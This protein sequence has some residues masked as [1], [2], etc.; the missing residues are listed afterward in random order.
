MTQSGTYKI[1][2]AGRH[3]LT[4]GRD[5]IQ[6][7]HAAVVELVK[8]AYD[9]DSEDVEI[10]F[11]RADEL[12]S[13][14]IT[15]SD[16]GHGMSRE[17]VIH[18]WLV[19]STTDKVDR[20]KSPSGRIMQGRKGVGRYAASVLGSDLW[21][22]T[23]TN[24]GEKT[25]V[26]I[27]WDAF[28]DAAY[29]DDVD[30]LVDSDLTTEGP[31]TR[32]TITGNSEQRKDWD[33]QQFDK[34]RFELRKL[35]SPI[36]ITEK[37]DDF[38]IKLTIKNFP[39]TDDESEIVEPYPIIELFD[40]RVA[41]RIDRNGKGE[42]NYST[43]K[44]R[45]SP[46]EL[47]QF[48][49][50]GPT[51]CG[52]L[53]FDFRVYDRDGDSIR[54]L[55]D[56]GLKDASGSYV[57]NLQARQL[58]NEYNGIGVYRNGFR[59]RPLG[60]PDF[61]WLKLNEQRVQNPSLRIGSNQVIG[62]VQI[63]SEELSGL[64][65]K[66]ARDGLREDRAFDSL[67][68]IAKK[69]LGELETRR[70]RHRRMAGI[71]RTVVR[72]ERQLDRLF[73]SE[74]LK[75]DVDTTLRR[76]GVT[77]AATDSVL[78]IINQDEGMRNQ[79]AEEIRRTVAVYQGQATLGKIVHVI[80]HEGR[81]PLGHFRNETNNLKYWHKVFLENRDRT[82][83]VK[84]LSIVEGIGDNAD[85]L[86]KLFGR[87]DPL[88]AGR[89]PNKT[90]MK[91]K[92]VLQQSIDVFDGELKSTE[93]DV[94]VNCPNNIEFVGWRQDLFTIFTNLIDN[95]IYW[96]REKQSQ[97]RRICIDVNLDGDLLTGIDY[98]DTGPGIDADF[99]VDGVIFEPE[100][101]TKTYGTG[102]GLPIAGEA[103][104]RNGLDLKAL[105]SETGA[106]FRLEPALER[107]D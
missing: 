10:V 32:L 24:H 20:P 49:Q 48:D 28:E 52:E 22:E 75:S 29:L 27:Q 16:H 76:A 87:L 39:S 47:I 19:P 14:R 57:G 84:I 91:L 7:V 101:T 102:L 68:E 105:E 62:V 54:A 31:G 43:Q 2:P 86:A 85:F 72:V 13:Y 53:T 74:Q 100:F 15:I 83:L 1:R 94:S 18:K 106:W 34:L 23:I 66:S 51:R 21:L 41:G 8:N 99:I 9:A 88:A 6:D 17:D 35:K 98:K 25:E 80:L 4:I 93:T 12:D 33:R 44:I 58:L 26:Y 5:L 73:S 104:M 45:N 107:E 64:I 77:R 65:E 50:G 67:K 59:L 70:F 55:I 95:S 79:V 103:A 30:I 69:V 81:R 56:R 82:I 60:D 40:Y 38:Q 42:L 11:E 36:Q 37:N 97:P 71:T 96:M 61:D 46:D 78:E 63:E 3:V 89:R 92:N 90:A